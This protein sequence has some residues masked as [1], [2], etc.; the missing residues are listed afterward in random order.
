[1]PKGFAT[2]PYRSSD[3]MIFV[4]VEGCGRLDVGDERLDF[5][6]HDVIV[7]PGWMP[8]T[9]HADDD[10]VLFSYSDRVAQEKLGI[11]R[12]LRG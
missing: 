9:L 5:A 3:S 2:K 6:P 8:Y 11:F 12:E 7:V 10:V 4:G 1:V